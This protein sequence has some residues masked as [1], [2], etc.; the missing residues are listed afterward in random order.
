MYVEF[1]FLQFYLLAV[2]STMKRRISEFYFQ[3][4]GGHFV[5]AIGKEGEMYQK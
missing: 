3:H 5:T 4:R 2:S 1:Y